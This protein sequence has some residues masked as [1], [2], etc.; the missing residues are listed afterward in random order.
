MLSLCLQMALPRAASRKTLCPHVALH[1]KRELKLPITNY[2]CGKAK[3]CPV[4]FLVLPLFTNT[5]L[6]TK[7]TGEI[8]PKGF[9]NVPSGVPD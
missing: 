9:R 8:N 6:F 5:G 3:F 2:E 1:T 7:W 4:T